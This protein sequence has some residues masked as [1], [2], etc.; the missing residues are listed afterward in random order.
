MSQE[1]DK[2]S[3]LVR[4]QNQLDLAKYALS[5][6]AVA[7]FSSLLADPPQHTN[8]L[9]LSDLHS[10]CQQELERLLQIKK[11]DKALKANTR[12]DNELTISVLDLQTRIL[13]GEDE[14]PNSEVEEKLEVVE[15]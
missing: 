7:L 11:G 5:K 10:L 4:Q 3:R 14:P 15:A 8:P 2:P 1:I 9:P 13:M 6:E 12:L